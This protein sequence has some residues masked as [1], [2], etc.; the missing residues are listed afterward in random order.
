MLRP[1]IIL[2]HGGCYHCISRVVDRRF[3]FGE[4]EM[5][6]F[7]STMRKLEAFLGVRVLS[8]CLMSNHFHLLLEIPD[9]E[10]MEKLNADS[11]RAK[12]PLLYH[13]KALAVLRDE[14]DRAEANADS[15]GVSTWLDELL[16]RYQARR[17]DLSVFLK[18]LKQRFTQWYNLCNERSG[19]LWEY[20][21]TSVI[22]DGCDEHAAMTMAAY[23]ELNPVRAGLVRDPMHYRWCSYAEALAGKKSAQAG[24]IRLHARTRA[25]QGRSTR[26][27]DIA[28]A[29][30]V[31]LFGKGERRIGDPRTGKG[32]KIG[33]APDQVAG[34]V[35]DQA[36]TL[37][38]PDR[39]LHRAR[40]FCDG[41]VFGSPDFV[42]AVFTSH[43]DR[44]GAK[45]KSGARTMRGGEWGG[46]ATLRDL[47]KN[48]FDEI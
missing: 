36:G 15:S 37:T 30:R 46:L 35:D 5:V 42:E 14:I 44:F 43:R 27:K 13:G 11:L 45:R 25:W 40:Y 17:G 18:E 6:Y 12:L 7:H 38:L 16:A 20:R 32:A 34:V 21:F 26:W 28:A 47:Q 1:R 19:T 31:H 3:I 2:P 29:Y 4:R 24:L 41:V 9:P 22:V 33:I 10:C 23:I 48:V 39:L 8:Y